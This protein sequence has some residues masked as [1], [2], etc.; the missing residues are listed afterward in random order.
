MRIF[1]N[2]WIEKFVKKHKISDSELLEAVERADNGL[3]DA[4][5]GGGVIKQRIARQ[6][7]GR[8]GGY[9]SLIFFRHGEWAFF[10]T[11]FAKND[12]ENIT[13]KELAELKKA[14]AIILAMTETD[15]EQA[16]SNGTFTEI[17][18]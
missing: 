12:R 4:D 5:L 15:I 7:Q 18:P 17:Q 11:A 16:K 10:M 9:R 1:K 3:I 2:Q 6:G 13:D 8:S 14:A